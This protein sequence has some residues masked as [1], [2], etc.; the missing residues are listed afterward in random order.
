MSYVN[1]ILTVPSFTP[2]GNPGEYTITGATYNNQG[3][4]SGAG[5]SAIAIGFVLYVQASDV[6]SFAPIPGKAHRYRVTA[7][8]VVDQATVNLTI[9]WDETGPE[10]DTPTNGVDAIITSVST[11]N[12]YGFSTE[13][14]LYPTLAAGLVSGML[15]ADVQKVTDALAAADAIA[16]SVNGKIGAVNIVAG[17]NI[18]VD[19]SGANIV[20]SSNGAN[21]G[22]YP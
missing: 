3:D 2:T 7:V 11:N 18:V 19:N 16:A 17:D 14:S 4:S 10:I 13:E 5:T 21:E 1:G 6:N 15:N 12:K 9:I 20:I 8:T 22:T